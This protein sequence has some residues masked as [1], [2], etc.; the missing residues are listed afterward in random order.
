M[1]QKLRSLS[2]LFLIIVLLLSACT[3]S[4]SSPYV[5]RDSGSS[6]SRAST[7]SAS[8]TEPEATE[9]ETTEPE[10]TEP[11]T[12]EPETEPAPAVCSRLDFAKM[13][14][15]LPVKPEA[16]ETEN[17]F[18][19]V[20][21]DDEGYQ[22]VMYVYGAGIMKGASSTKFK[23]EGEM[24]RSQVLTVLHKLYGKP[25]PVE[26]ANPFTDVTAEDKFYAPVMWALQQGMLDVPA[27]AKFLPDDPCTV[28][29]AEAWF[30]DLPEYTEP[31]TTAAESGAESKEENK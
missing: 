7:P 16:G 15:A 5:D 25:E 27:D 22:A 10:S 19:D 14:F 31:E 18:E 6:P 8:S 28:E 9:P 3:G 26:S 30:S 29:Q 12:T 2:I 24:T 13:L 21:K 1:R 20:T 4:Q 17:P 23:P 11:E